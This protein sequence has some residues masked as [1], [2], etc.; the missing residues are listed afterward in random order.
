MFN[1][2]K[3]IPKGY[4]RI[5][6]IVNIMALITWTVFAAMTGCFVTNEGRINFTSSLIFF[7]ITFASVLVYWS[8]IRV[9]LWIYDGFQKDKKIGVLK[10]GS[11]NNSRNN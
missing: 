10:L 7:F 1:R 3:Q 2:L 6:M 8:L 5:A 4:F 11:D 9:Y